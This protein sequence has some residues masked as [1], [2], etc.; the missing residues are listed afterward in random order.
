[1]SRLDKHITDVV[2]FIRDLCPEAIIDV[3]KD[4]F[5]KEDADITVH[6]PEDRIEEIHEAAVDLTWEILTNE[7][8]HIVLLMMPM[9]DY[10]IQQAV[11]V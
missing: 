1:M 6:V 10:P 7:G 4:T 9:E 5:E 3:S 11:A 8:Y 2:S